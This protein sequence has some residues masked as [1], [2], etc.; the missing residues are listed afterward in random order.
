M[1]LSSE[2]SIHIELGIPGTTLIWTITCLN[3]NR[4]F[5]FS[6]IILRKATC[7]WKRAF[8]MI[9]LQLDLQTSRDMWPF[10]LVCGI[11][12]DHR[13]V[14]AQLYRCC[15]NNIC[16]FNWIKVSFVLIII[17]CHLWKCAWNRRNSI[18][19]KAFSRWN[20]QGFRILHAWRGLPCP[21]PR[22]TGVWYRIPACEM[23][24]HTLQIGR[25][26]EWEN[27]DL[28]IFPL[29]LNIEGATN[30]KLK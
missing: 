6:I 29:F 22:Y 4:L 5:L 13:N 2:D 18:K 7:A 19:T 1:L 23:W 12:E 27:F 3:L 30:N 24:R 15:L 26:N 21:V 25:G 11:F 8:E 28:I 9:S 17:T 20:R 10:T 16:S 14:S